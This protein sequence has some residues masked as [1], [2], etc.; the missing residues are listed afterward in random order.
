MES[1]PSHETEVW[2]RSFRSAVS[3]N[4]ESWKTADVTKCVRFFYVDVPDIHSA[5][6]SLEFN[7]DSQSSSLSV[8]LEA[9]FGLEY[10]SRR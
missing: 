2:I 3:V 10:L 9:L 1:M 4:L 7:G 8:M 6:T 5:S